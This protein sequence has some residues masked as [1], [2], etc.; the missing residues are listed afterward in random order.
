MRIRRNRSDPVAE[1]ASGEYSA[2]LQHLIEL[3][4]RLLISFAT[5]GCAFL[6]LIPFDDRLFAA[7][8]APLL[9][10]LP[11]GAHMI[12]IH[13]A[14]PFLTPLKLALIVAFFASVPMLL[15]QLWGFIAPALYER[16]RKP[17]L[18]LLVASTALF[19]LGMF[20][21]YVAVFPVMFRFFVH[22]VPNGV[23]LM[24]DISSYLGFVTKVLIAFG[25][26]FEIPIVV[27]LLTWT[28]VATPR[29]FK[30]QRPYV[31]IGC[32]AVG[33]LFAPPDAFSQILL[34]VPMYLLYEIGILLS[35]YLIRSGRFREASESP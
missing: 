15:H 16:E 10:R 34:A 35:G 26:A 13:V 8:S 32:F 29:W 30:R 22:A 17:T 11:P 3:R 6:V 19:Y 2:L 14:S 1:P 20:F 33:A 28:G 25:V 24:A 21:A 4:R 18:L 23:T 12:A 31:L 7:L 9:A 27:A 5:V